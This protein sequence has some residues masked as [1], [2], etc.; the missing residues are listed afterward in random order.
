MKEIIGY[1]RTYLREYFH[2]KVYL[3]V[4]LFAA[5][6]IAFNYS[7][8]FYGSYINMDHGKPI[9]GLWIFLKHG[10]GYLGVCFILYWFGVCKG[11]LKSRSFW[12]AFFLGFG[13]VALDRSFYGLRM[14]ESYVDP[15]DYW[16]IFICLSNLSSIFLTVIPVMLLFFFLEKRR[17]QHY[18]GFKMKLFRWRPYLLMLGIVA[19]F[20]LS[21]SF[22]GD[23]QGYY[24]RYPKSGVASFL[25]NHPGIKPWMTL[26][27]YQLSYAS[28]FVGVE[29][30]F[31]GFLILAFSRTLGGHAV[32]PMIVTYAFLHFGKPLTETISSLFGGYILGVITYY[33]RSI[34]GGICLH[35][36][37]AWMMELFGWLQGLRG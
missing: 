4:M 5:A 12:I 1:F 36:G 2:L 22:F 17:E 9:K 33:S 21:G 25:E 13:I 8:D 23:I 26:S 3:A 10:F 15:K 34:W 6:G 19:L 14:I 11:W 20:I 29:A 37:I 32:L 7:L 30:M 31:R 24:P 35:I 18:Y 27:F 16:F 28:N